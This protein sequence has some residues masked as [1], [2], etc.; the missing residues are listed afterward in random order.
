MKIQ[1]RRRMAI[2]TIV[3]TM[4]VG[5]LFAQQGQPPQQPPIPDESQIAQMVDELTQKLSLT[6]EQTSQILD[7]Y[8]D[9]FVELKSNMEVGQPQRSKMDK[10]RKKFEEQVKTIL[11][12]EQQD[13]FDEFLKENTP[14]RGPGP[15]GQRGP[16]K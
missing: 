11:T 9:H 16:R 1:T 4:I 14:Q 2:L 10:L 12:D 6:D 5:G 3:S 7:L 15:R 8:S 13:Q